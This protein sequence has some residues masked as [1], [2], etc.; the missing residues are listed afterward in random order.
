MEKQQLLNTYVNSLSMTEAVR[1]IEAMVCA[2]EKAFVVPIN[3]DVVMK[4]E[5]DPYLNEIID[6]A[7]LV[8][9]DGKP[10]IWISRLYGNP[11]KEKI[12]GSD[13]VPVLCRDAAEKGWSIFILGGGP[14]DCRPGCRKFEEK[15]PRA[16]DCG[17]LCP[18]NRL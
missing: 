4:A 1:A 15:A 12:S 2:R 10:L 3:V 8:L 9:V 18:E 11:V 17:D 7:Q 6:Q 13:L 14:Q 5:K 16:Q